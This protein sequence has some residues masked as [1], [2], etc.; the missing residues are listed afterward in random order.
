MTW[1]TPDWPAPANI[2]ALSTTRINGAS[3]A[4]FDSFNLGLHVGDDPVKVGLNRAHLAQTIGISGALAWLN[5]V[6][7]TNV[8]SL[9]LASQFDVPDA[10]GSYTTD[11][12]QVCVVMTADCLPVLFC[13]KQGRQVAAAHAGWR[14]LLNGVLE[15]TLATFSTPHQVMA[16]LGPA[17]GADAFEVGNEVRALFL[18]QDETMKFAFTP[19]PF[20][21]PSVERGNER[22]L[23]DIYWL[24]KRRLQLAGVTDIYGGDFC[25]VSDP[26][27]F[28][29]Y[30]KEN[31]TGR[32]ASCIWITK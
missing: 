26:Q 11:V 6:H 27:R 20:Q 28:F 18:K 14:G 15:N 17:I 3:L 22:W 9:P 8:V 16:W 24:A 2:K 29:S 1:I 7:G 19:S 32:Q 30:R 25:T 31:N 12:E 21:Q 5:Q 23:A 4:P 13:D 10:D